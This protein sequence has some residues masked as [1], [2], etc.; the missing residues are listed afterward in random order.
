MAKR[1]K[2][3]EPVFGF[4]KGQVSK[5]SVLEPTCTMFFWRGYSG[6]FLELLDTHHNGPVPQTMG[7]NPKP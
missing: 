5:T 6:D 4:C 1:K 3:V 7:V 2:V